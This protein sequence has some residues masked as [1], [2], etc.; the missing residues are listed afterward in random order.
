MHDDFSFI[1]KMRT[2]REKRQKFIDKLSPYSQRKSGHPTSYQAIPGPPAERCKY[3][4]Q[5]ILG[6]PSQLGFKAKDRLA[7]VRMEMD[8][9][10][11]TNKVDLNPNPNLNTKVTPH[12]YR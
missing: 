7:A 8:R 9:E 3:Y 11:K 2:P 10:N 12:K 5:Q 4:K 6:L 1:E